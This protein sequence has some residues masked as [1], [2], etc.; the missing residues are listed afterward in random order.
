MPASPEGIV[1]RIVCRLRQVARV[2]RNRRIRRGLRRGFLPS[3]FA[4]ARGWLPL[5][6]LVCE[7]ERL[8]VVPILSCY[9]IVDI[10]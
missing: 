3:L 1:L 6:V 8:K 10:A 2:N 4:A 5:R 9:L 7:L